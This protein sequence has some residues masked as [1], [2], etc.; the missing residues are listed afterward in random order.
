MNRLICVLITAF[1][2]AGCALG[3]RPDDVLATREI[4]LAPTEQIIVTRSEGRLEKR[5]GCLY[6][7]RNRGDRSTRQLVVWPLHT[8]FNGRVVVPGQSTTPV[9]FQL[10]E[11]LVID[12]SAVQWAPH[13]QAAYPQLAPWRERCGD[14]LVFVAAVRRAD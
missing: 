10:G 3:P 1:L 9:A 11:Q 8:R 13:I 14:W 2:T 12:G 6:L 7:T 4:P 5:A